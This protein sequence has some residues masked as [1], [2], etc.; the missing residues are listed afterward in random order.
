MDR[1]T[2]KQTDWLTNWLYWAA[3]S[4]FD[5]LRLTYRLTDWLTCWPTDWLA[6]WLTNS[7]THWLFDSL[8]HWLT[9]W[10]I[11]WLINSLTHWLTEVH[12][13]VE[14]LSI[15]VISLKY[16]LHVFLLLYSRLAWKLSWNPLLFTERSETNRTS[17]TLVVENTLKGC[18][19]PQNFPREL[20]WMVGPSWTST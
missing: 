6:Y 7:S 17:I 19:F 16:V 4:L 5:P 10:L 11:E 12:D 13:I 18:S 8:T 9:E 3:D 14:I 1:H 2:D 20:L 15:S